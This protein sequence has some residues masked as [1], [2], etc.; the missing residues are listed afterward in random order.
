MALPLSPACFRKHDLAHIQEFFFPLPLSPHR[1]MNE[2]WWCF[3]SI[4]TLRI[5]SCYDI[6]FCR[7]H[8][9]LIP[10]PIMYIFPHFILSALWPWPQ[11]WRAVVPFGS[12]LK[13]LL[14][15]FFF[16]LA[17]YP[18]WILGALQICLGVRDYWSWGLSVAGAQSHR[19]L[20]SSHCAGYSSPLGAGMPRTLLPLKN[21]TGKANSINFN[22]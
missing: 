13:L 22:Q 7:I 12:S 20:W 4:C 1:H 16:F 15:F 6:L 11:E 18:S 17:F 3:C 8:R 19:S 14:L 21:I 9:Q 5:N 10:H 2:W